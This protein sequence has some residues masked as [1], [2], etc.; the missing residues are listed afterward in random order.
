MAK[1]FIVRKHDASQLR[2]AESFEGAS[3][4]LLQDGVYLASEI[5]MR[6]YASAEDARK[7]G[8]KLECADPVTYAEIV[9][10]LVEEGNTV[11]NL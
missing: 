2:L 1:L 7:R 11:I 4:L 9:T 6:A 3:T 8:V 5:K 10:L